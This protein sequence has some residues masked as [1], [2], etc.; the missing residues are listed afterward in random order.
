MDQIDLHRPARRY[1]AP[2]D[3]DVVEVATPPQA[4]LEQ[5]NAIWQIL[6]PMLGSMGIF[7]FAIVM[8]DSRYLIMAAVL[9]GAMLLSGIVSRIVQTRSIRRKHRNQVGRYRTHLQRVTRQLET[10]AASQRRGAA[11]L[12]PPVEDLWSVAVDRHRVW[13]RR[14]EHEDFFR[15]RLGIGAVTPHLRPKLVGLGRNPLTEFDEEMLAAAER[16]VT[17]HQSIPDLPVV[18]DLAGLGCAAIVG[19][20]TDTRSMARSIISQLVTFRGPDDLRLVVWHGTDAEADWSWCGR[21]PHAGGTAGPDQPSVTDSVDDLEV[22]LDQLAG[23]RRELVDQAEASPATRRTYRFTETVVVLDGYRPHTPIGRSDLVDELMQRASVLG[24]TVLCLVDDPADTP[25]R[26]GATIRIDRDRLDHVPAGAAG[27]RH[28]H[29]RPDRCSL[30]RTVNLA[31]LLEPLRPRTTTGKATSVE[32]VGL[33]DLLGISNLDEIHPE[34]WHDLDP[35]DMLRAPIGLSEDG[36]PLTLDL[37]ESSSGG[38]GPHG[39][40]IG[41]TGSGKSELLRTLVLGLAAQHAPEDLAM[42]LVD[43]K[44]G[45]TFASLDRLPHTAGMITNLERD[46]SLIDRMQEALHGELERRQRL[47][48]DAGMDRADLYRSHRSANPALELEPMPAL[49][50]VVDEFGELLANRPEF[51]ELFLTIGRT[52]RSLGVHLL[53]SSQRL[54]EGSI[55]KLEGHLRY[56]LCLRTFTADESR[57]VIGSNAAAELP[58]IPGVGFLGVDGALTPFKAGLVNRPVRGA[59]P[60]DGL[61]ATEMSLIIDRLSGPETDGRRARPIWLEPLPA[62]LGLDRQSTPVTP[63]D[64][65]W[66]EPVIG[67]RDDPRSQ[68][69]HPHRMPLTG[70]SGH[71]AVVGAPRSGKSTMLQTLVLSLAATH[72]PFDVQVYG[73]DLGGGGLHA[74]EELPHVGAVLGRSHRLEIPRLIR[75]LRSLVDVRADLFR[76]HEIHDIE[77]FHRLR[78]SG[79]LPSELGEVVLI[80][81]NWA[82]FSQEFSL[83]LAD[84]VLELVNGGLH[85]GIHVVVATPRWQDIRMAMRDNLGGRFEFRLNDPLDSEIDRKLSER[86]PMDAPGRALSPSGLQVQ[87][88]L[89]GFDIATERCDIAGEVAAISDR[90]SASPA[91]PPVRMLPDQVTLAESLEAAAPS[92]NGVTLGIEETMLGQWKLDLFGGE[93]HFIALGDAESGKTNL[94][95][96]LI[97]QLVDAYTPDQVQIAVVDRRRR[98]LAEVPDAYRLAVG[99]TPETIAA[100]AATVAGHL[101]RREVPDDLVAIAHEGPELVVI[102]DDYDQVAGSTGNPLAPLTDWVVQG[103]DVG[104]HLAIARR[105]GGVTRSSFEPLYQRLKEVGTPGVVLSGDP[106]EGPVLGE[107]RAAPRPPG[108]GVAVMRG[109]TIEVQVALTEP[110]AEIRHLERRAARWA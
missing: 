67:R 17:D 45:A 64:D 19:D 87:V 7:G 28:T 43:F 25:E 84:E 36:T 6:V 23:P 31:R 14:P 65:G 2:V 4:P 20:P 69:L 30:A 46:P 1:P 51:S 27:E 42:V 85:Y 11:M 53:L 34:R 12:Y 95:R 90:W 8:G 91:A 109:R 40:L 92:S 55:R 72:D 41:A 79:T 108:R 106:A 9:A 74:L 94:L 3:V 89:P 70:S 16:L 50:V 33:L 107:V 10:A 26:A 82:V 103:R 75:Q 98:L 86:L 78:R 71:L 18:V 81:D 49:L 47:L 57:T 24:F 80:V 105:V 110:A 38:Q 61:P 66:L 22:I 5:G 44:G 39:I 83:D 35:P 63:G 77:S 56:R 96:T 32:S 21:L 102:V 88:A 52:G 59:A 76:D 48:H 13:E 99:S 54:E 100:L 104:F 60:V 29:V 93:P 101:T 15:V 68:Q 73:V 37:K 58:P 62:Q 97:R